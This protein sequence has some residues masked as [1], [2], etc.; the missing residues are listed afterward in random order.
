MDEI[1]DTHKFLYTIFYKKEFE[2]YKFLIFRDN[3]EVMVEILKFEV[4][5]KP[6][7]CRIYDKEGKK[8]TLPLQFVR[9]VFLH[10]ELVWDN[11][12]SDISNIKII[13]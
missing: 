7:V 8:Y 10:D 12:D 2:G 6:I 5:A 13:N 4:N 1:F 11:T 3:R 9:K